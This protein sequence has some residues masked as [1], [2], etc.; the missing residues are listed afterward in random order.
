M[1]L[2]VLVLRPDPAAAR[3]AA[4]VAAMGR[5]PLCYPLFVLAPL[6]WTPPDPSGFDAVLV[7]SANAM[8]L[9]GA[10]LSALT[11]LP[12]FAVG[13]ASARAARDAGFGPVRVGGGDLAATIP[14]IAQTGAQRILHLSGT[15]VRPCD[16]G[17]LSITRIPVY[18]TT[19]VGTAE[20]LAALID[21]HDRLAALVHSP[22]A[23]ERLSGLIGDSD[24]SRIAIAAISPAAAQACGAGWRSVGA[25]AAPQEDALLACLATLV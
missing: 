4:R 12:A 10:G 1:S 2:P 3:T 16:P 7:S 17:L 15:Q 5:E 11:G 8:R 13:E 24:R 14:E 20:G 19:P 25:A 18:G 6:D 22:R 23:G 21:P 9:G